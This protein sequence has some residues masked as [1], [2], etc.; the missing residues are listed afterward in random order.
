L[1]GLKLRETNIIKIISESTAKLSHHDNVVIRMKSSL[2]DETVWIDHEQMVTAFFDLEQNAVE[3][4]P[5]GGTLTIMIEGDER[6]VFITLIDRGVGIAEE[7]IPLLFTPFFTTKPVGDGIGL[8]LPQ[9]FAAIK[10]HSGNISIESNANPKKGP[11]GT[12]VRISLPRRLVF[13]DK[14]AKLIVHEEE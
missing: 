13:Q 6:Q 5:D 1:H 2:D 9:A 10:A 11:T 14:Q 4:M 3:A 8:G 7:Y 12:T